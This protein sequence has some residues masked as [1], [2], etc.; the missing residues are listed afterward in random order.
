MM[1]ELPIKITEIFSAKDVHV[2]GPR[3]ASNTH[4]DNL[5]EMLA[6]LRSDKHQTLTKHSDDQKYISNKY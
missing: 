5:R 1:N 4:V 3:W 6:L 2:R